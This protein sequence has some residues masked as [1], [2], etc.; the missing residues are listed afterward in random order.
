MTEAWDRWQ[1]ALLVRV[2][3]LVGTSLDGPTHR[4]AALV[5]V[6]D[7]AA[8]A[9]AA[10]EPQVR[11]LSDA[12]RRVAPTA[13][14]LHVT[15]ARS[16]R[17]WAALVNAVAANWNEVDEGYRPATCHGGL[18]ALPAAMAEVE[19]RGGSLGDVLTALVVGY[20]VATAYARVLPPPRPFVLHPHATLAPIGAAAA[21]AAVRGADGP[22]V[23]AAVTVAST[24]AA[25]G[26][27]EH[28]TSGVLARNGWAGHGA[29]TGF[30]AVELAAAGVTADAQ[31]PLAVLG[32][33]LGYPLSEAELATTPQRWAIHDG[34]H[35]RY[36]CCQYAHSAVEASLALVEG[37]LRDVPPDAIR[38]VRVETHQL[39]LA[40]ADHRP[41]TVLGGKFSVPH[42]VASVLARGDAASGTFSAT[43]LQDDVVRRI[44]DL[45]TMEPYSG[46]LTPPHDRPSRVTV[47]LA[48]GTVHTAECLSAVGGPDRPLSDSEV[49][50][51]ADSLTRQRNPRFA[52]LAADLVAGSVPDDAPWRDVLEELWS[53]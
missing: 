41:S 48:D 28:A 16:G 37:P 26:P 32:R 53:S 23:R 27:F 2:D 30:T 10:D 50:D 51:K 33:A 22:G 35:K 52:A 29:L 42:S 19:A 39:A 6:D 44:S 1:D 49:L 45:V 31:S 25:V 21:V 18:Y 24:L 14:S 8:I 13:E 38:S 43:W 40:L 15:G 12:G 11:A 7:L 46:D 4:R 17:G 3:G 9:S 47:T 5:L 34:Y 36:A 20:E